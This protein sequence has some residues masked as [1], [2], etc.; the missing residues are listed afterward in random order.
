[1][2]KILGCI[3]AFLL[4]FTLVGCAN[5]NNEAY[6]AKKLSKSTGN[7]LTAINNLEQVAFED[8]LIPEFSGETINNYTKN[9]TNNNFKRVSKVKK[10]FNNNNN[11]NID[12][13]ENK[14]IEQNNLPSEK[15]VDNSIYQSKY[16]SNTENANNYLDIFKSKMENLYNIYSDCNFINAECN[17]SLEELKTAVS[18]CKFLC[19]K[20]ES[21]EIKL[22]QEQVDLCNNYANQINL[23]VKQIKSCKGDC[24]I[25]LQSLRSLKGNFGSNS[26][27]LSLSYLNILG[28]LENRLDYY[29]S[30]L[31]CVNNCNSLLKSCYSPKKDEITPYRNDQN[32]QNNTAP[33]NNIKQPIV[34]QNP[35]NNQPINQPIV[36]NNGYN[37]NNGYNYGYNGYYGNNPYNQ[38]P[39]NVN[40]YGP[41]NKNIDTYRNINRNNNT[42][43]SNE[44]YNNYNEQNNNVQNYYGYENSTNLVSEDNKTIS[45][46]DSNSQF[47]KIE[48]KIEEKNAS[49]K[50]EN[51]SNNNNSKIIE[52]ENIKTNET[53]KE[54]STNFNNTNNITEKIESNENST[55][56]N[57]TI[58]N[59]NNENQQEEKVNSLLKEE[60][61]V[62]SESEIVPPKPRIFPKVKDIENKTIDNINNDS[63]I[64][65]NNNLDKQMNIF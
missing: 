12:D 62:S 55:L 42:Y 8:V 37:S 34:N 38:T 56:L 1:M 41:I 40:T 22:T 33:D 57:K 64:N 11:L 24:N 9:V 15:Y 48:E 6:I 13:L 2:K 25:Y 28:C 47:V 5:T 50:V 16:I 19:N 26:D 52:K 45:S 39:N 63:N 18:E 65:D 32:I 27:T 49:E 46:T 59:E 23:C 7:L 17:R 36:N 61:F 60:K 3:C 30:A 31:E 58:K 14:E 20:L 54:K 51:I 44:N 10:L 53:S 21:G 35:I 4:I 29:N 43:N